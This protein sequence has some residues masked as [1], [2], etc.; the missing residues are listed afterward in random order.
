MLSVMPGS[1][2]SAYNG[3]EN[4][5]WSQLLRRS[6]LELTSVHLLV[7]VNTV[8]VGGFLSTGHSG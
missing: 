2:L 5:F 4:V 7:S 1:S 6:L 8:T 3:A